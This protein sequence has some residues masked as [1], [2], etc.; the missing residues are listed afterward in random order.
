MW[1]VVVTGV[2]RVVC[3]EVIRC[4]KGVVVCMATVPCGQHDYHMGKCSFTP[5]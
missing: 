3:D 1:A 2:K 5:L 4:E